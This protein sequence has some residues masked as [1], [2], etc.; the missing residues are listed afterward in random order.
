MV[1]IEIEG[2]VTLTLSRQKSWDNLFTS[3]YLVFI[4]PEGWARRQWRRVSKARAVTTSFREAR[5]S[6]VTRIHT[7]VR[8]VAS[9]AVQ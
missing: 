7:T 5:T 1:M 9:A 4:L 3:M 2:F 6:V 8:H